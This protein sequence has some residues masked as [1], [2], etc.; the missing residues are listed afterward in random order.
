V[1][2]ANAAPSLEDSCRDLPKLNPELDGNHIDDW[3][4]LVNVDPAG[5]DQI[6]SALLYRYGGM[7]FECARNFIR[8]SDLV[9]KQ[10]IAD[11]LMAGLGGHEQ[12]VREFEYLTFTFDLVIDQGAYY[13]LKRH[14]MM[15]QTP[16]ILTTHLGYA[17]PKG[18]R[19]SGLESKYHEAMAMAAG[20]YDELENKILTLLLTLFPMASNGGYSSSSTF[21]RLLL[22]WH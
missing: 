6:L 2:Y 7:S 13:E 16:Q 20:A 19:D 18:F 12:P 3:C 17:I 1:K 21:V 5:E 11:R 22:F 9:E 15:T 8:N 4:Q 10:R 14:R